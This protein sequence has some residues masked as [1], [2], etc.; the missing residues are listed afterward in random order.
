[1]NKTE[2]LPMTRISNTRKVSEVRGG[3]ILRGY[4][5]FKGSLLKVVTENEVNSFMLIFLSRAILTP[6]NI[7]ST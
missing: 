5:I 4:K 6:T 1:M 3:G 7:Q 2:Q